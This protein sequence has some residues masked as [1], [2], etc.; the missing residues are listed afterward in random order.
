MWDLLGNATVREDMAHTFGSADYF[1]VAPIMHGDHVLNI[2]LT[3]ASVGGLWRSDVAEL[4]NRPKRL[5]TRIAAT[6][7]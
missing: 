7:N 1:E 4:T 6:A 5:V 3:M 2:A